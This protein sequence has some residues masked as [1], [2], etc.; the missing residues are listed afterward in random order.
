M[1]HSTLRNEDRQVE[2]RNINVIIIHTGTAIHDNTYNIV[3]MRECVV[4]ERVV[5]VVSKVRMLLNYRKHYGA[6]LYHVYS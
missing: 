1:I 2:T 5:H 6:E 3:Y 4:H